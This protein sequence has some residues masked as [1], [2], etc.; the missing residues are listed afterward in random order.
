MIDNLDTESR[1]KILSIL[2][3]QYYILCFLLLVSLFFVGNFCDTNDNDEL[4]ENSISKLKRIRNYQ[5]HAK[6]LENDMEVLKIYKKCKNTQWEMICII[7]NMDFVYNKTRQEDGP[8]G[9]LPPSKMKNVN[10][11]YGVCRDIAVFRASVFRKLNIR[12]KFIL[13]P[14]HIYI[15]AYENNIEFTLNNEVITLKEKNENL[16]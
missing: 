3:I 15:K 6:R 2:I 11:Y 7:N 12:Y 16:L 5:D 9:I 10:G 8:P 1:S 4:R 13:E 14:D